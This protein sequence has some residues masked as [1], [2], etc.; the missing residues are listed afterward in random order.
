M[1][2]IFLTQ[3]E[4]D[5][6]IVMEKHRADNLVYDFPSIGESITAPLISTDKRESFLIDISRG[7]IDIKKIKYQNRVRQ[8]VVLVRID[9]EGRPHRNPDNSEISCPHIHIFRENYA[10]KWAFPIPKNRFKDLNNYWHTLFDFFK[11]CNIT[12]PPTFQRDLFT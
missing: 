10:D 3:S 9:L 12:K 6:L 5:A 8:T 1:A 7:R 2:E 11:Y 4:A